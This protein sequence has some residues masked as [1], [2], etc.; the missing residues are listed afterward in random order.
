MILTR[1]F[2]VNDPILYIVV[3][4]ILLLVIAQSLFFMFKAIKRS[5]EKGMDQKIIKKTI[6]K[7]IIFTIAPAF[8]VF[9][10]IVSLSVALGLPAPWLR[11]SVV[12][13]ITYELS[14]AG[15]ALE[16]FGQ[17][18]DKV[19][20]DPSTYVTV[21]FVMSFGVFA[22]LFLVPVF[23]KK[24]QSG[25]TLFKQKDPKWGSIFSDALFIGM[26]AAFLGFVFYDVD[27][28][29]K[30]STAGLIPVCVMLVSAITMIIIGSIA[31]KTK[32]RWLYDYALPVSLLL[33]MISAI[34]FT[35]L[36]G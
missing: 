20:T 22:G 36:L 28:I 35:N 5:K 4:L 30:G 6:T 21:M 32:K 27:S 29:F 34:P 25:L 18:A 33:G 8:S 3:G 7:S 19:I 12:G 15:L 1:Q 11:L 31:K 2:N 23:T 10:G 16:E 24:I 9:I 13:S 26:I 14:A 17:A